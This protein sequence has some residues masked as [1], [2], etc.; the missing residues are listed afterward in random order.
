MGS[1]LK[2]LATVNFF[3]F[4]DELWSFVINAAVISWLSPTSSSKR[5]GR[6]S[7]MPDHP[8][9][10]NE[11]RSPVPAI[12]NLVIVDGISLIITLALR[13]EKW[14][15]LTLNSVSLKIAETIRKESKSLACNFWRSSL[16][17]EDLEF[18][19]RKY[20]KPIDG[21]SLIWILRP[22]H[23][24]I[25]IVVRGIEDLGSDG[26]WSWAY[27]DIGTLPKIN[28]TLLTDKA[29]NRG[30]AVH[31]RSQSETENKAIENSKMSRYK[32]SF[33]TKSDELGCYS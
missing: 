5:S 17:H 24:D 20:L 12:A 30:S 3:K 15:Q 1:I 29:E 31:S 27:S 14:H 4:G 25:D 33:R 23:R 10:P 8:S 13:T 9:S 6:R 18:H 7:M 32:L 21:D 2:H 26:G 11:A 19:T 22:Q 28:P 16:A